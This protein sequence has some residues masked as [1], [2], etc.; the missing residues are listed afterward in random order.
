MRCTDLH[1]LPNDYAVVGESQNTG[2]PLE[3]HAPR[4]GITTALRDLSQRLIGIQAEEQG[5]LKRTFSRLFGG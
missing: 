5:L 3:L 4:A 2:V 1:K